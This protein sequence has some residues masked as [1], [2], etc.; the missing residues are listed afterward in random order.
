M[1]GVR[2]LPSSLRFHA[3]QYRLPSCSGKEEA[4]AALPRPS[5]LLFYY[6]VDEIAR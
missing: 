3:F 1:C 6:A 4:S 2:V 5:N